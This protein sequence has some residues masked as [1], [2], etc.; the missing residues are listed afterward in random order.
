MSR[1]LVTGASGFIGSHVV[2]ALCSRGH[3][4]EAFAL[5]AGPDRE[6]VRWHQGDLFEPGAAERLL[7]ELQPELLVHLAWYAT[8]GKFWS[9]PENE[10]WVGATLALVRAFAGA[11]GRRAV[12]TGSCAEY[13]WGEELLEESATALEPATFYGA[14][15]RDAYLGSR[16]LAAELGLPLAWGRVFFLYG[17][18]EPPGRLV[19]D[20]ARGLLAGE[21][22]PT[23]SGRQR[24]DFMHV[25]DVAGA[26]AALLESDVEGAV[27]IAT[28]EP[29]E[30]R[31]IVAAIA[32]EAGSGAVAAGD[33]PDRDGEPDVIAGDP[34]RLREE[35][36]FCP[37]IA[38]AEGIRETVAWHRDAA[39]KGVRGRR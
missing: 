27:N 25:A 38:L 36:G 13:A 19:S 17:P 8:P 1:V 4:V 3:E 11:G 2:A 14:C 32:A 21:R 39:G 24:R 7:G 31:E 12:L 9:A 33:L 26:L 23:T 20:V 37:S 22:V 34:R 18:G 10:A 30:V 5:D 15:K 29:V 35:V 28:G 6:G 16:E